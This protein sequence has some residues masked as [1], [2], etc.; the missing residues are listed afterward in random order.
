MTVVNYNIR[1]EK[2]LRDSAFAVLD[3]YGLS[4]SQAIKLFLKQIS[5][6]GSVPLSFD[7][8]PEYQLTAKAQS[9]LQQ[10]MQE[11]ANGEF[12]RYESVDD[13]TKAMLELNQ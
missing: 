3:H 2:E 1:I 9:R 5:G 8:K 10:S 7:W 12:T 11:R 6:T 4:P 13:A